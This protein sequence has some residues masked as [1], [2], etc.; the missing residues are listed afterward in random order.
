MP[1]HVVS[2]VALHSVVPLVAEDFHFLVILSVADK[3]IFLDGVDVEVFHFSTEGVGVRDYEVGILVVLV[4]LNVDF[5]L[6]FD[7]LTDIDQ[8]TPFGGIKLPHETDDFHSRMVLRLADD[9]LRVLGFV[10]LEVSHSRLHVSEGLAP[11]EDVATPEGVFVAEA[12]T[13]DDA[14]TMLVDGEDDVVPLRLSVGEDGVAVRTDTEVHI[15]THF[16]GDSADFGIGERGGGDVVEPLHFGH[17]TDDDG[18][19]HCALWFWLRID[20]CKRRANLTLKVGN[21]ALVVVGKSVEPP[22]PTEGFPAQRTGLAL[23]RY[24]GTFGEFGRGNAPEILKD[25]FLGVHSEWD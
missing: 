3:G 22:P 12:T 19:Q 8:G 14:V 1:C 18:V 21:N 17:K 5:A 2:H 4:G 25:L 6:T 9:G 15:R 10:L 20:Y 11:V 24:G 23:S 16:G 7:G 13:D